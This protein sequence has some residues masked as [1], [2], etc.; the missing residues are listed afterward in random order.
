M[1]EIKGKDKE[2]WERIEEW[3]VIGLVETGV[4]KKKWGYWREKVRKEYSWI[5]GAKKESRKEG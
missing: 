1:A 3:D 2:F 5:Q 4:E